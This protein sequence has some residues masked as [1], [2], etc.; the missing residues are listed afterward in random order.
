M[1]FYKCFQGDPARD[2]A[3]VLKKGMKKIIKCSIKET[4][5]FFHVASLFPFEVIMFISYSLTG[6]IFYSIKFSCGLAL[7]NLN[8]GTSADQE[9]YKQ[10]M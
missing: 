2:E 10:V 3:L 1:T 9:Q 8:V 4:L 6:M 5:L 7:S